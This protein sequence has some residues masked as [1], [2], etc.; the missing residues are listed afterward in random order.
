[1]NTMVGKNQ[2]FTSKF[3]N[4]NVDTTQ[5]TRY[6]I[7]PGV[8]MQALLEEK[9]VNHVY[10]DYKIMYNMDYFFHYPD[11]KGFAISQCSPA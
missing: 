2:K 1:M 7:W 8:R 10:A 6:S 3:L 5:T 11:T 4:V 9:A